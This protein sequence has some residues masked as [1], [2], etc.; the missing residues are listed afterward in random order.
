MTSHEPTLYELFDETNLE[1]W[2][3]RIESGTLPSPEQLAAL[4]EQNWDQPLPF[5]LRPVV[6]QAVRGKLKAKRGRPVKTNYYQL[7]LSA[8]IG[9]YQRL[10][11]QTIQAEKA[12]N[13]TSAAKAAEGATHQRLAEQVVREWKLP[14]SWSSFLNEISSRK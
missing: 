6:V 5:W 14:I 9:Q 3:P 1:Y 4:L 8:A 12:A 2:R 11:K 7:C 13:Q 10:L